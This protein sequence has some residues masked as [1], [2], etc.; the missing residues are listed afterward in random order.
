MATE[1]T[2]V[3]PAEDTRTGTEYLVLA[4]DSASFWREAKLVTAR[5]AEEAVRR[6]ASDPSAEKPS[7]LVAVPVRSWRP[8][9]VRVETQT[10]L[11]LEEA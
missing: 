4:K 6:V 2:T 3:T 1:T 5:S 8:V 10:R 9:K 7:A 11:I